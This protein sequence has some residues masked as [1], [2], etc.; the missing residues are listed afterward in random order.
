M[1]NKIYD[2]V[3]VGAGAAGLMTAICCRRH[4]LEVLLLDGQPKIGAKILM[5][6]GTRCNVTNF[7]VNER[8]YQSEEL[9]TVRN[10]LKAFPATQTIKFFRRLGVNLILEPGGK[11]FPTTHSGKTVLEAFLKEIDRLGVVLQTS[12]KVDHIEF[13]GKKFHVR[14][15]N[16]ATL[17]KTVVLC[18]GGLSYP[19][20]GSDGVGYRLAKHF[21]HHLI[22]TTPA[23]T[24]FGTS[25][26]DWKDL[27]GVTLPARLTL[28]VDGKKHIA[29]EDSFLFTH[30]GYSG[31]CVL[32]ISRHWI[33]LK[34]KHDVKLTANFLPDFDEQLL[35]S[36]LDQFV[37]DHPKKLTKSFLVEKLP[38]RFI[39][40]FLKKIDLDD[41]IGVSQLKKENRERLISGL[42]SCP[43]PVT[44]VIGYK[45]AEVTAG[46]VDFKEVDAKTLESK[47]QRGL[48]FAGEILDVDGRIGGFNFQW[49]W[50]SGYVV[51]Q[52]IIK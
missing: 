21:G 3:I 14:G 16:F 17:S 50:A 38:E 12:C 9:R 49:A 19:T 15:E 27:S 8:D 48:F 51:A 29:Y 2:V 41:T 11:Y 22:P 42:L 33:R 44:G 31:P 35:R 46:G 20:T 34:D 43:L 52:A 24:P 45:K 5:S 23:L 37:K 25:D 1:N 36:S 26:Q 28:H 10:V 40:T 32:D 47:L 6:G 7:D 18:S 30:F 39:E 4:G 13:D